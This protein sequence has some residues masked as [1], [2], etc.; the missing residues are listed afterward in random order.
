[1]TN[2]A[3]SRAAALALALALAS[4]TAWAASG[5]VSGQ[6]TQPDGRPIEG[7]EVASGDA[8]ART[9]AGGLYTLEGVETGPRVVVSFSKA[10]HATT[11][12]V[13]EVQASGDTDGDGVPDASDVCSASDRR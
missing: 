7:V 2:P 8:R 3:Y 6:V 5:R 1:M 4:G 11:Y 13:V 10:G 9:D 12:G